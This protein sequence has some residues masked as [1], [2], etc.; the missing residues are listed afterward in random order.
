MSR[1]R[2]SIIALGLFVVALS[3]IY[4]YWPGEPRLLPTDHRQS[5][6]GPTRDAGQAPGTRLPEGSSGDL[7][8]SYSNASN[9]PGSGGR[10]QAATRRH[11]FFV[12]GMILTEND[13]RVADARVEACDLGPDNSCT[14][15]VSVFSDPGGFYELQLELDT[16]KQKLVTVQKPGFLVT[17]GLVQMRTPGGIQQDFTLRSAAASLKGRVLGPDSK[18]VAG[19]EVTIVSLSEG[20]S[21]WTDTPVGHATIRSWSSTTTANSSGDFV[22]SG[23]PVGNGTVQARAPRYLQNN[24]HR[25]SLNSGENS[26][27]I[28]LDAA[29][30]VSFLVKNRRGQAV[31]NVSAGGFAPETEAS[32]QGTSD[33]QGI[34]E[35]NVPVGVTRIECELTAVNY[36]SKVVRMSPS[37]PPSEV[38]L[39]DGWTLRGTVVS[40]TGQA[41][42][43]ARVAVVRFVRSGENLDSKGE[44]QVSADGNG[45]FEIGVS[46]DRY[47]RVSARRQGYLDTRV[48]IDSLN[49]EQDLQIVMRPPDGALHGVVLDPSGKPARQFQIQ[50]W[51]R[52]AEVPADADLL[53]RTKADV[54]FTTAARFDQPGGRFEFPEL[55]AGILQ[56]RVSGQQGDESLSKTQTVQIRPGVATEVVIRFDGTE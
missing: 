37:A 49:D 36:R 24:L 45:R 27:D 22:L 14:N 43:G 33:R 17:E 23:L 5:T 30:L 31:D 8:K 40:A 28:R 1:N 19:A 52:P 41:L 13:D 15:S 4:V 3:L 9:P 6:D 25:V 12:R 56:L 35:L 44:G 11:G 51:Q 26:V 16:E 46:S 38:I 21:R 50:L 39:D 10:Q 42:P 34:V 55:P 48:W 53:S 7:A 2:K 29:T 20:K 18:P 54:L 47:L 32:F